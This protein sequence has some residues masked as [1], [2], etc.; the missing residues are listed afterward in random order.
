MDSRGASH[1]GLVQDYSALN[2][3]VMP[4]STRQ[5]LKMNMR[6][7]GQSFVRKNGGGGVNSSITKS[8]SSANRDA[9]GKIQMGRNRNSMHDAD[10]IQHKEPSCYQEDTA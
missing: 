3:P 2:S 9:S 4:I 1:R 6:V 7:N 10:S 8:Q 5:Q